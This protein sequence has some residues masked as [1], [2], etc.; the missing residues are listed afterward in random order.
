MDNDTHNFLMNLEP[1]S[2]SEL[3]INS[4]NSVTIPFTEMSALGTAFLPMVE[5]F[6]TTTQTINI[7]SPFPLYKAVDA[8]NNPVSLT[9][10][11]HDKLGYSSLFN[12][13]GKQEVAR[14]QS[15]NS[16]SAT[17]Q[18]T[19]PIDPVTLMVAAAL[20]EINKKL[21]DIK[22]LQ[23]SMY[24]FLQDDKHSKVKGN[25][26]F[27]MDTF[28]NYKTNWNSDIY[29]KSAHIK[30]LDI[31]QEA[32]QNILFYR[33]Q[34]ERELGKRKLIA[35]DNDINKQTEKCVSDFI[36]YKLSLY[37]FAFSSFMEIMLIENYDSKYL[38]DTVEKLEKQALDYRKLYTCCF[39]KIEKD[40]KKS[41]QSG[42]TKGIGFVSKTVGNAIANTPVIN[43][44]PIDE[45]LIAAGDKL[46]KFS[47]NKAVNTTMQLASVKDDCI[48]PFI[49]NINTIDNLYN[50]SHKLYF[51]RENIYLVS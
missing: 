36:F 1:T 44:T 11:I 26:I 18:T 34:I 42:L 47:H 16:L 4:Q 40:T 41:I 2:L 22:E 50:S 10:M 30:A 49:D 46:Q 13:K 43:K 5:Q 35:N 14:M 12:N 48:R 8:N 23:Q 37:T 32:I 17:V 24:D 31:K 51:D 15:V 25:L 33:K 7:N 9:Y 3:N 20:V 27:L 29:K 38:G 6:R 28:K 19:V 39:N 21:D 45:G